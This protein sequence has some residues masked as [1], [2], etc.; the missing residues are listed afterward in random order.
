MTSDQPAGQI[1]PSP[2]LEPVA[3]QDLRAPYT[4]PM[5]ECHATF[6]MVTGCSVGAGCLPI[7]DLGI[8]KF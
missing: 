2:S 3:Q 5:L 4:P 7:N 8:G 6:S 1:L